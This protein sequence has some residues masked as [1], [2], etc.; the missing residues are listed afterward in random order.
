MLQYLL[1]RAK[2]VADRTMGQKGQGMVE[3]AL[4]LAFVVVV[5]VAITNGEIRTQV[6]SIFTGVG[7]ALSAAQE[8]N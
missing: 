6:M 5:A 2:C 4:I 1:A 8:T 3:Y 7:D